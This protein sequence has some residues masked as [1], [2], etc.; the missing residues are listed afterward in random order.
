MAQKQAASADETRRKI[1]LFSAQQ[2]N[3][4]RAF[5][6]G[7]PPPSCLLPAPPL[8]VSSRRSSANAG[9]VS[10]TRHTGRNITALSLGEHGASRNP[11]R[12]TGTHMRLALWGRF[13]AHKLNLDTISCG[14]VTALQHQFPLLVPL[15][16]PVPV[17][18]PRQHLLHIQFYP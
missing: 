4:T 6:V 9:P 17:S 12:Q 1:Q 5:N 3:L 18:A 10:Q 15:Q 13:R 2:F 11:D 8:G 16:L 7:Y 14:C